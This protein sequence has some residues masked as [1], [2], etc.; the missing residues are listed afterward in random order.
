MKKRRWTN[1]QLR[2][3]VKE[4][5][6][7]RKVLAKIG[8][9]EAGGNYAQ[10]KQY[11]KELELDIKHFKGQ[12]WNRGL[13]GF[14]K[15]IIPLKKILVKNSSFQSFKLKNRLYAAGLKP[16]QCEECGWNRISP[17][18]RLP[19]EIDHINGNSRDNRLKNLKILCPNC[20]SLKST[21]RGRNRKK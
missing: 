5:F 3:A 15:P 8:L 20:H 16:R 18:G 11:I 17:D 4:S 10:V 21:H 9:I 2:T 13:K 19:L 14:N 7:Y 1:E 6:S 12:G